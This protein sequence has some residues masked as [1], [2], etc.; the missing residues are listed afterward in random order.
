LLTLQNIEHDLYLLISKIYWNEKQAKAIGGKNNT[1]FYP[2][3]KG[4]VFN[5]RKSPSIELSSPE[6]KSN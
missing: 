5:K 1:P 6:K 3:Y 4:R 2:V